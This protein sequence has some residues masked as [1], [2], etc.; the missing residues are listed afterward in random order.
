MLSA[1][2]LRFSYKLFEVFGAMAMIPFTVSVGGSGRLTLIRSARRKLLFFCALANALLYTLYVDMKFIYLIAI[3][4]QDL[5]LYQVA[6]HF[7]FASSYTFIVSW[8]VILCAVHPDVATSIL[9]GCVGGI[10]GTY[11]NSIDVG[12]HLGRQRAVSYL[13]ENSRAASRTRKNLQE[14]VLTSLPVGQLGILAA[15]ISLYIFNHESPQYYITAVPEGYRNIALLT[16]II[17]IELHVFTF[18]VSTAYFAFFTQLLF[19]NY[20]FRQFEN[21]LLT[22][23]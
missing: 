22:S 6:I 9:S 11:G 16:P 2:D 14:L 7:A 18:M 10:R 4:N 15:V 3:Q 5:V 12:W 21:C 1:S 19:F 8:A 17:F 13:A 20:I 23:W